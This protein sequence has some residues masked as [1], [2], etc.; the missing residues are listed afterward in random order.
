MKL[1]AHRGNYRGK[2]SE[3]ENRVSY[4]EEALHK[5]YDVEID[6]WF[7]GSENFLGHD[8]PEEKVSNLFLEKYQKSLW[9]HAKSLETVSFLLK[10]D[11]NWF[12]HENDRI[13]LTSKFIPWCYPE[14]FIDNS[15][16]NQPSDNSVFWTETL[17]MNHQYY[18]ICHDDIEFVKKQLEVKRRYEEI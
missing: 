6:L 16:I 5:G 17:W 7:S 8:S 4:I 2:H 1:I 18:G 3:S 9:I 13:T 10:T 12:W 14:I 15:V 11:Y